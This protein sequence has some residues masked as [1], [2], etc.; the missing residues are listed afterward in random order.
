ML[1]VYNAPDQ[2]VE[3]AIC[4]CTIVVCCGLGSERAGHTSPAGAPL[5]QAPTGT[6]RLRLGSPIASIRWSLGE[7]P[8]ARVGN[9][10]PLDPDPPP[11]RAHRRL[12]CGRVPVALPAALAQPAATRPSPVMNSRRFHRF[13]RSPS[14]GPH[15][16]EACRERR[17]PYI[18][19]PWRLGPKQ[20][21]SHLAAKPDAHDRGTGYGAPVAGLRIRT[22][23]SLRFVV[24]SN[25]FSMVPAIVSNDAPG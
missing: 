14:G 3:G 1:R 22:P 8:P 2:S 7:R 19:R 18:H 12:L 10:H 13:I 15:N 23:L 9:G 25:M 16:G 6:S 5:Y 20:N 21:R 11:P 24:K 4:I 17:H